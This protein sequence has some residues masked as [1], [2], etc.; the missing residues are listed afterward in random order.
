LITGTQRLP[1]RLRHGTQHGTKVPN[2]GTEVRWS[3]PPEPVTQNG[4]GPEGP[5][6]S[7][8]V[9]QLMVPSAVVTSWPR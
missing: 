2:H 4:P 3:A 5:D 1:D 9:C 6:P 7:L 8:M